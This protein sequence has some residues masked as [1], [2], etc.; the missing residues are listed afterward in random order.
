CGEL[1]QD[2]I[3]GVAVRPRSACHPDRRFGIRGVAF[4]LEPGDNLGGV[5]STKQRPS[6][7]P[8]NALHQRGDVA[9]EPYCDTALQDQRPRVGLC[10]GAATR[11]ND[12]WTAFEQPC[13]DAT[14]AV[15]KIWLA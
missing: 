11:G 14:L 2:S 8:G 12:H 6:V 13:K 3:D 7:L 1:L 5:A 4:R 15:A 10:K 9:V